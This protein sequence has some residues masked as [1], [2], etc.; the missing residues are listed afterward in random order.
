M[1]TVC[2]HV[3]QYAGREELLTPNEMV[4]VIL[5]SPTGAS[6][7][8]NCVVIRP[9][10]K[11]GILCVCDMCAVRKLYNTMGTNDNL[12]CPISMDRMSVFCGTCVLEDMNKI[13]EEI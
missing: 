6:A 5:I 8:A 7:S 4:K 13:M 9:V 11:D 3:G 1:R 12:Y 2:I 10:K